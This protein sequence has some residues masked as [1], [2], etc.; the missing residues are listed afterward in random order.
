MLITKLNKYKNRDSSFLL[1]FSKSEVIDYFSCM[2]WLGVK[3]A[4]SLDKSLT[5]KTN[6]TANSIARWNLGTMSS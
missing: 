2:L 1:F 6:T 3:D 4:I 5:D